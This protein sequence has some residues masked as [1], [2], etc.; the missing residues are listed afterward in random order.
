MSR[1]Y[2]NGSYET[3]DEGQQSLEDDILDAG[4]GRF[5]YPTGDGKGTVKETPNSINVYFPDS[6]D[7]SGHSHEGVNIR[8]DHYKK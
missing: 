6:N 1:G 4:K 7:P 3:S 5:A 8:G 2:W